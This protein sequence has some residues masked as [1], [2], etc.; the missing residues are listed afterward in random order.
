VKLGSTPGPRVGARATFGLTLTAAGRGLLDQ[1]A[2]RPVA[3]AGEVPL[4][5]LLGL[6]AAAFAREHPSWLLASATVR[7][8]GRPVLAGDTVTASLEVESSD[9]DAVV[10][11]ATW[12][13]MRGETVARGE[14]AFNRA[15]RP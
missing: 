10:A 7:R 15:A 12:L 2:S 13:N 3:P 5:T 11:S 9:A 14:V 4:A 6:A 8:A 1:A